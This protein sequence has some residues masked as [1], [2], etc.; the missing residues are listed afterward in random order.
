MATTFGIVVGIDKVNTISMY[1]VL[2]ATAMKKEDKQYNWKFECKMMDDKQ[3]IQTFSS[4]AKWL[5]IKL[6]SGKIKGSTGSLSRFEDTKHKPF[7]IISQLVSDDDKTLGYKV[8]S[9]DGAVKNIA[10]KEMIAYGNRSSKA[11]VV[12]VQNAIFIAQDGDKKAH[13]KSYPNS[14][15]IVEVIHTNKNKYTEQKRVNTVKN[16]KTLNKL[17]E[18]YNKE[19]IVELKTGKQNGVDIRI[20]ANPALSAKQMQVLRNGLEKGI[21]VRA[22]AFPE[23]SADLMKLYILDLKNGLDIRKYLNPRYNMGQVSE[24]SL[25]CELGLDLSKMANPKYTA[26]EMS[27]IRERLEAKIWKDELVKKDGS[28]K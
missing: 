21:N 13:Y 7:V 18:I 14:P 27:E 22:V 5:N 19:Q 9:Y 20:Y 15:F 8:A 6:E 12:P 24:L 1:R 23:Y 25:A 10:I 17:E 26:D 16:E 4:G 11:G 2:I 3:V 28:W